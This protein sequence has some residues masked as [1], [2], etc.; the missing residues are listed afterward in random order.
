MM[1]IS[2][3]R[4]LLASDDPQ[5]RLL[6]SELLTAHGYDV[7]ST[8]AAGTCARR[9]AADW[10]AAIVDAAAPH[11]A[12]RWLRA[13][14]APTRVPTIAIAAKNYA[15]AAKPF[16]NSVDAVLHEPFDARKLLLIMRGLIAGRRGTAHEDRPLTKG[17][18][19]LHPLLNAAPVEARE[20]SL[21]DVET[22]VLR[23]LMLAASTPVSR[24]RLT[25]CSLG[26]G[27]SPDDRCLD[28]HIKRL[29]RKL[30]LDRHGRT[31]IQTVRGSA[32]HCSSAAAGELAAAPDSDTKVQTS[33]H[34]ASLWCRHATGGQKMNSSSDGRSMERFT[35][36]LDVVALLDIAAL[37]LAVTALVAGA[38]PR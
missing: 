15:A 5:L 36:I 23:E 25:R 12:A 17:P 9:P 33:S 26:R 31:P 4:I 6:L 11:G 16:W 14:E 21:T 1:I 28:T 30:G 18:V 37:L 19:T 8:G 34:P 10:D 22:R 29:R 32:I 2:Q 7:V 27:W 3:K 24:D 13:L 20:T 38:L 35:R